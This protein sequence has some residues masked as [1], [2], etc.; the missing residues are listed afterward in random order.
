M[1]LKELHYRYE[2]KLHKLS[3]HTVEKSI[4]LHYNGKEKSFFSC[5]EQSVTAQ[6]HR[7]ALVG[8]WARY[9]AAVNVFITDEVEHFAPKL[10]L[11]SHISHI[12]CESGK[13]EKQKT[14]PIFWFN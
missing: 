14:F 9:V 8:V 1:Y 3:E 2:S 7:T 4:F 6:G 10:D 11:I 12:W 13:L 5:T